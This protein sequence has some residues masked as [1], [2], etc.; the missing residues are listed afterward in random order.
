M[1]GVLMFAAAVQRDVESIE[2]LT[3]E[4]MIA[5]YMKHL[6]PDSEERSKIAIHLVA[7]TTAEDVAAE[8]NPKEQREKLASTLSQVLGQLG[9]T[10]EAS[11]VAEKL[12]KVD[13]S[14][15]DINGIVGAVGEYLQTAAALTTDQVQAAVKQAPA[16]LQQ[17]LPQLGIKIKSTE[18]E[19]KVNGTITNGEKKERKKTVYIEDVQAWKASVPMSPAPRQMAPLSDFEELE[20]K[21]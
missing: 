7:A 15:G 17:I 4:A 19:K 14:G 2:P 3:K 21:L 16:A 10:V 5:F 8:T 1:T 20:P 9:L 11:A 13:V 12:E 18:P 6:H